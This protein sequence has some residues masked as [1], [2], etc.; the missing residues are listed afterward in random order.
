MPSDTRNRLAISS[1]VPSSASYAP[2]IRSRRSNDKV[3]IP[4]PLH[5]QIQYGYSL[6][7]NYLASPNVECDL[8]GI[9]LFT[10]DQICTLSAPMTRWN[11][12][13]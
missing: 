13:G 3:F 11:R 2:T 5:P 10:A 6:I 1:L 8:L 7:L 12:I 4:L 9:V